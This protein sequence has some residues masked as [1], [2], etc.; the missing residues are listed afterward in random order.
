MAYVRSHP[1]PNYP[2]IRIKKGVMPDF[3]GSNYID[4]EQPGGLI[5]GTNAVFTLSRIPIQN[6]EEIFKDGMKM[7]RADSLAFTSGDYYIDYATG[8]ITFS[9][10]QV[11]QLKASIQVSYKYIGAGVI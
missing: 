8:K 5:D 11:P 6:T 4:Q 2:K 1:D 9:T 3:S 10:G 7:A